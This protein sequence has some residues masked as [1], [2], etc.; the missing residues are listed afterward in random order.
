MRASFIVAFASLV[1]SCGAPEI[2]EHPPPGTV[3]S[4]AWLQ[5]AWRARGEDGA[6]TDEVWVPASPTTWVGLN[7]THTAGETA[8][9]ELLRMEVRGEGVRYVAAPAGQSR[10]AFSLVDASESAARFCCSD[11]SPEPA[12][13]TRIEWQPR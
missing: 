6:V 2:V 9:H 12:A 11:G 8:H 5:G 3:D 10:T 4:I 7:R 13:L 1:A